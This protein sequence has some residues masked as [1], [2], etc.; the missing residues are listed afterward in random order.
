MASVT[1]SDFAK[2]Y[3]LKSVAPHS[4][5]VSRRV[6]GKGGARDANTDR[7]FNLIKGVFL[8]KDVPNMNNVKASAANSDSEKVKVF[9]NLQI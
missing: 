2:S 8:L 3:D 6:R 5:S 4:E 9:A 1:L 7:M